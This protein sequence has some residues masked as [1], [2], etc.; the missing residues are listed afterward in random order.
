MGE[1]E[2]Q[3]RAGDPAPLIRTIGF[4]MGLSL[5]QRFQWVRSCAQGQTVASGRG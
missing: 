4:A 3:R 5:G 2:C 1:P